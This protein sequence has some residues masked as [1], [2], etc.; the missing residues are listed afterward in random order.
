MN[1]RASVEI[2]GY[3]TSEGVKKAWD[4]RGRGRNTIAPTKSL[5]AGQTTQEAWQHDGKWDKR[6]AD[7]H[8][9]VVDSFMSGKTPP[10]GRKPI[11]WIIGGGTASGKTTASR[12]ILGEQLSENIV[13]M[14]PDEVKLTIPE[15]AKLKETDPEHA[16]WRVHEESSM[17]TK[18]GMAQAGAKGLDIVYDS[19]TSGNTGPKIAQEFAAKGYDVRVLFVDTPFASA[20][21]RAQTRA[22]SSNDPINFGRHV[23]ESVIRESH[24]GAAANFMR[25]KDTPGLTSKHFYDTTDRVPKL[26]YERQ[27]N[28]DEKVHDEDR[29]QRYQRK[30]VGDVHASA[31]HRRYQGPVSNA[32]G[33]R[34]FQELLARS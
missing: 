8:Q 12:K 5:K 20:V 3:G 29:W 13:R 31:V 30:A 25:L 18:M 28:G 23:P 11:V 9:S 1:L 26:I 7:W 16:A 19:T 22:E 32:A 17:M 27:G 6:R 21:Q 33:Y 14:D 15:Y 4:T 24:V 34:R 2:Y 10:E